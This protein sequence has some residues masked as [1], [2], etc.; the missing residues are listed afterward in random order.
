MIKMLVGD[1]L[2]GVLFDVQQCCEGNAD[3]NLESERG[4][5]IRTIANLVSIVVEMDIAALAI[6]RIATPQLEICEFC[7]L[8]MVIGIHHHCPLIPIVGK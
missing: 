5:H 6:E 1:R 2:G 7:K 8:E 4:R 3:T